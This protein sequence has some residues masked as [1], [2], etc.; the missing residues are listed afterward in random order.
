LLATL[1]GVWQRLEELQSLGQMGDRLLMGTALQGISSCLPQILH[2][3]MGIPPALE[4]HRQFRS[5]LPRPCAI[6][7]LLPGANPLMQ[8]YA[9]PCW[10]PLV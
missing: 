4:M 10:H 1:E 6:A 3:P 9:P 7:G 8:P 5:D 2:R